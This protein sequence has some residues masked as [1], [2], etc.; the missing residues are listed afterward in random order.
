MFGVGREAAHPCSIVVAVTLLTLPVYVTPTRAQ[1][2]GTE[3]APPQPSPPLPETTAPA[4][5][6]AAVPLPAVTVRTPP[7]RTRPSRPAA[8]SGEQQAAGA[9]SVGDQPAERGIGPVHGYVAKQSVTATKTD[10]PILET[11]Q[12]ISVVTQDQIAS[13]GAQTLPQALRYVPGVILEPYGASSIFNDVK[14]RGFLAPRYLDGLR[15][16]N[17]TITTFA[18]TRIEPWNLERIEVLKGPSSGLYGETSPGGLVSMVSKRPTAERQNQVEL[19]TGSFN[20]LQAAFDFSGPIDK[21]QTFLYRLV[22][23]GRQA[24][25]VIDDTNENR[26]FVAPSFTWRPTIDTSFTLLTSFQRDHGDGQPQQY[27]PGY[28]TLL[29]NINGRIPYSRNIGEPSFDHWRIKQDMIGYSFEH[30][31]NEVFQFRQNV[32]W[33]SVENDLTSMRNELAVPNMSTTLRS[34]LAVRASAETFGAD[35]HMQADF[36]TGPLQHKVL[37]GVDYQKQDSASGYSAAPGL[38]PINIYNPTYGIPIPAVSTFTP[39][40]DQTSNQKQIG[41]YVQDQI[42]LDRWILTLTG[43]RD[44]WEAKTL[45]RLAMTTIEQDSQATTGRAGLSYVFDNGIAPYVSYSTSFEPVVGFSRSGADGAAFKP[46]TGE[47]REIGVKYQPNG[48]NA[49]LTAS[50]FEITQQ[51]VLTAD[52]VNPLFSIQTGEVRVR[53][54]EFDAKASLTERLDIVGGFTHLEPIVTASSTGNIGKDLVNTP[55]DYASLW[56]QYTFRDGPAAG[57][58]IGGGVRYVGASFMDQLNTVEIPGYTLFDASLSYDFAYL[59]RSL[60]GLRLQINATNLFDKYYVATC[61]TGL[62][63]CG[64]GAPRTILATL[65]YAWN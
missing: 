32:R 19:Q 51:N 38:F 48:L 25:T 10:T 15:L 33:A 26:A 18:Q 30:R 37:F 34:A 46:T 53:G 14:I 42:K 36:G 41:I 20:R 9:R 8:P 44:H 39:L 16:P 60:K 1:E 28:G 45:N 65:K 27:V 31:F 12:P 22:G 17:D 54:Y 29:P 24:D 50:L 57:L 61:Y 47:G 23:L 52:P 35:N 40:T 49:L 58:G 11:P 56:M 21:D 7:R 55:R 3:R 5:P 2:N 43:R 62:P 6:A 13:Q 4:P 59:D 64:L 63:Y